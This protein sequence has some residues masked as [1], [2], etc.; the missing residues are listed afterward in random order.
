MT[1][2]I[3]PSAHVSKHADLEDSS[4][5]SKIVIGPIVMIDSFVK[6]KAAGGLGNILIGSGTQINSGCVFILETEYQLV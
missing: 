5:G 4:R 3:H 2:D 1:I 6:F